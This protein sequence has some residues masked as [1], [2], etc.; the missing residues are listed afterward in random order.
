[1]IGISPL[2]RLRV[3]T[4]EKP[5]RKGAFSGGAFRETDRSVPRVAA[6][7]ARVVAGPGA[8]PTAGM[9][10]VAVAAVASG[11]CADPDPA[12]S[13][14]ISAFVHSGQR[15]TNFGDGALADGMDLLDLVFA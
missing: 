4:S 12:A 15:R 7:F 2:R 14:R 11:A 6:A 5:K 9:K 1:M 10:A 13:G 8:D 3:E